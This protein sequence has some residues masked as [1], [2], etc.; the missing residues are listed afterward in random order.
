[1]LRSRTVGQRHQ[2]IE[3]GVAPDVGATL[4]RGI[5][6]IARQPEAEAQQEAADERE[7][8]NLTILRRDRLQRQLGGLDDAETQE[9]ALLHRVRKARLLGRADVGRVGLLVE[10]HLPLEPGQV[11]ALAVEELGLLA[12]LLRRLRERILATL[13]RGEGRPGRDE[14]R[15]GGVATGA[16]R[17]RVVARDRLAE[18]L[19]LAVDRLHALAVQLVLAD[20]VGALRLELEQ[21]GRGDTSILRTAQRLLEVRDALLLLAAR[22]PRTRQVGVELVEALVHL[23][24]LTGQRTGA[25]A[26]LLQLA[27]G[28]VELLAEELTLGVEELLR[29]R[30]LLHLRVMFNVG[31]HQAVDEV[32]GPRGIAAGVADLDDV[33]W[34]LVERFQMLEHAA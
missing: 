2:G 8:E 23:G 24:L 5:E 6:M 26:R 19:D 18:P 13:E 20:Q 29:L 16:G 4:Q 11:E 33:R 22:D 7:H 31:L 9:L 12:V 3:V 14:V 10:L 17:D 21:L 32:L 34:L 27:L 25:L 1:M 15:S 30:D 28:G